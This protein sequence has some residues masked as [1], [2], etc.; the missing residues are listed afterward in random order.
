[1]HVKI[2]E[3]TMY[4]HAGLKVV[5]TSVSIPKNIRNYGYTD[6]NLK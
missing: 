2:S 3:N 6:F 4:I 1:M 5:I